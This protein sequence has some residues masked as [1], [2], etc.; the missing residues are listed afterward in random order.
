[1]SQNEIETMLSNE[2][3]LNF[4]FNVGFKRTTY[5]D[6]SIDGRNEVS[7]CKDTTSLT[8]NSMIP[9]MW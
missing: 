8:V 6:W 3:Y 5:E 1:M 7:Q 2:E 4:T 9:K